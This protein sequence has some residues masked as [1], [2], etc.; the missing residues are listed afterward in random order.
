MKN[1]LL[2]ARE[3]YD[4]YLQ[5]TPQSRIR[6]HTSYAEDKG[7]LRN[8]VDSIKDNL[9]LEKLYTDYLD[10]VYPAAVLFFQCKTIGKITVKRQFFKELIT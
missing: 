3:Y 7:K 5:G 9:N 8:I 10:D 6:A 2:E 1:A 4:Q